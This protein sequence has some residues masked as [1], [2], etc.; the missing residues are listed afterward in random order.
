[1]AILRIDRNRNQ[2]RRI[3]HQRGGRAHRA[4]TDANRR[5]PRAQRGGQ[6]SRACRVADRRHRGYRRTPLPALR[7]VLRAA[8]GEG[9]G[10]RELLRR[11]Q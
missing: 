1:M 3:H 2:R 8:V 4:R 10:G 6:P 11:A 9:S 5:R 7:Q